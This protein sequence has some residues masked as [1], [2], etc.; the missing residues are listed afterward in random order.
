MFILVNSSQSSSIYVNMNY[1]VSE[2][3]VQAMHSS[4]VFYN[5]RNYLYVLIMSRTRFRV[6]AHSI[7]A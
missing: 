6:Y 7:V 3:L 1:V 2:S 5:N 4:K